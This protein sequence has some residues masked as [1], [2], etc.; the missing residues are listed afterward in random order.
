MTEHLRK[1][2]D[3]QK[4]SQD[5]DNDESRHQI[6]QNTNVGRELAMVR[7]GIPPPPRTGRLFLA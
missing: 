6:W 5:D 7:W 3:M 2:D 4:R 1:P